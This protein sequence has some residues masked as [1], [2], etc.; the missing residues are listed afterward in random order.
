M[1]VCN[2]RTGKLILV[3]ILIL[4]KTAFAQVDP[5]CEISPFDVKFSFGIGNKSHF[6]NFGASAD[7]FF[8]KNISLKLSAGAGNL[9]YGGFVGSIGLNLPF[10][11]FKKTSLS[12]GGVWT[13]IGEGFDVLGDDESN[14]WINYRSSNMKNLKFYIGYSLIVDNQTLLTLEAGYSHALIPYNYNF[15]GPGIP[16]QKQHFNIQRGLSSGWMASIH[17]GFLRTRKN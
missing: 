12:L 9:N 5:L 4:S 2:M 16:T 1:A 14:D 6:G 7:L 10:I 15:S 17:I 8:T 11:Y 3:C 13:Y